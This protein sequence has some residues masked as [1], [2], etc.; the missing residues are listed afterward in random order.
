[1]PRP[2]IP[3]NTRG[4]V[5]ATAPPLQLNAAGQE[6]RTPL[7]SK[8]ARRLYQL[9]VLIAKARMFS[10]AVIVPDLITNVCLFCFFFLLQ[11]TGYMENSVSY[12]A[13][14][15]VQL[16]SWENA[17]KYCLQLTIPGGTV[18]LQVGHVNMNMH[19]WLHPCS[20][21][22]SSP[23]ETAAIQS[24]DW[25]AVVF[26]PSQYRKGVNRGSLREQKRECAQTGLPLRSF[27]RCVLVS[28]VFWSPILQMRKPRRRD[29]G[30]IRL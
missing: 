29:T 5:S 27:P 4:W 19:F 7:V 14:E 11:P 30:F 16:L 15:D 10:K 28:P 1:M 23:S 8:V 26:F 2:R 25:L 13:I 22:S 24:K 12:S 17:P 20:A 21:P 9:S 6:R 3:P 18:L